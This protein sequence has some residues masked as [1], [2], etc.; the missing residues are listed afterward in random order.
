MKLSK[1]AE[2][3]QKNFNNFIK[4]AFFIDDK[5]LNVQTRNF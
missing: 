4:S 1:D 3:I 5:F 2:K